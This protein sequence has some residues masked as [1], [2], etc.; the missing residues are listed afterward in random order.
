[1]PSKYEI[2]AL[3]KARKDGL[4]A[5]QVAALDYRGIAALCAVKV[6]ANGNSPADFF[7][8]NVRHYVA[9]TLQREADE[10]ALTALRLAVQAAADSKL[11]AGERPSLTNDDIARLVKGVG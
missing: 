7:Y 3:A 5:A 10:A 6:E 8:V 1:M 9:D 11:A 2:D 4:T